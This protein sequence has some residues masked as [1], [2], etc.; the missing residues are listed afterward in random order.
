MHH[1][2]KQAVNKEEEL[3]AKLQEF[4]DRE[5]DLKARIERQREKIKAQKKRYFAVRMW[6]RH[7][8]LVSH[9]LWPISLL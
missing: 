8:L 9:S 3:A 1:F 4:V 5:S 7:D 2:R 6:I